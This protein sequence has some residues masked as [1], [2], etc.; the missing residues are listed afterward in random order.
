M[1]LTSLVGKNELLESA[2][3]SRAAS[4]ELYDICS[5]Q[6]NDCNLDIDLSTPRGTST[7]RLLAKVNAEEMQMIVVDILRDEVAA[8]TVNQTTTSS[9]PEIELFKPGLES[10]IQ[11]VLRPGLNVPTILRVSGW[12]KVDQSEANLKSLQTFFRNSPTTTTIQIE[13]SLSKEE[14]IDLA[15]KLTNSAIFLLGTPWFSCVKSSLL[16]LLDIPRTESQS[17]I[18][19][20]P[21]QYLQDIVSDDF[22]ALEESC[23]IFRLGVLL[24]EIALETKE[25][26]VH[27]DQRH[28]DDSR[29]ERL[30]LVEE[31][32]GVH[33]CEATAWCLRYWDPK[34][35]GMMKYDGRH[36]GDWQQYLAGLLGEFYEQVFCR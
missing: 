13:R 2:L 28:H 31:A 7:Y 27:V 3:Q 20:T 4:L 9:E 14:K 15:F 29:L 10:R 24:M 17:F 1:E 11:R 18:L 12:Q 23:Q 30:P 6:T 16:R 8:D 21:T 19:R 25:P 36:Y 35:L 32:M 5:R 33:Y 22:T 26:A 34:F